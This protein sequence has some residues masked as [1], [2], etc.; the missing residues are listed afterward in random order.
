MVEHREQQRLGS[1]LSCDA[2][3][4]SVFDLRADDTS[5]RIAVL[6]ELDSVKQKFLRRRFQEERVCW[7]E[8]VV[9]LHVDQRKK[10]RRL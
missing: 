7:P 10:E 9:E 8:D 5:E 6:A 3:R 1:R 2:W 4:L